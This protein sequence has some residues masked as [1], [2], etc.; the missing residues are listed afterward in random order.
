MV[1]KGIGDGYDGYTRKIGFGRALRVVVLMAMLTGF[2]MAPGAAMAHAR[3]KSSTPA[4]GATVPAGLTEITIIFTEEVS[5]DQSTAQVVGGG[6]TGVSVAGTVATVSRAERT[7]M[8]IKT[9]ALAE[10]SYVVKWQTVTEDDNGIS[11]GTFAFTVSGCTTFKETGKNMCGRFARYWREHGGLTQQGFPISAE[12]QEKSD[13]DGKNYTVQY[14]ECAVLEYHPENA[15]KSSEVLLSLL[16]SF[17]YKQRYPGGAP[18]QKPNTVAGSVLFKETG[19]R[20]G[21]KFLDYWNKNGGLAQQGF[22]ISE[23]FQER[24]QLDGKLY[25]IHR[26]IL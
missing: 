25:T 17:L 1:T 11:N 6:G 23:E 7:K 20:V 12:M 10:G 19:K 16:G 8:T 2:W 4:N 18:G 9:P 22:P 5:L 24:S 26:S 14:F 13:T 21:G 3:L 15:G